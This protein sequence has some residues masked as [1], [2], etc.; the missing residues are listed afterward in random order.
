MN[1]YYNS[2]SI[3]YNINNKQGT[4]IKPVKP[5]YFNTMNYKTNTKVLNSI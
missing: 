4:E 2:N 1:I 5:N 3:Y